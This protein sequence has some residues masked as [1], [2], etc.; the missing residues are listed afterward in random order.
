MQRRGALA[1]GQP[2]YTE[3]RS[4]FPKEVAEVARSRKSPVV[5]RVKDVAMGELKALPAMR[6]S[7]PGG[8]DTQE[9]NTRWLQS[10]SRSAADQ[11]L[12]DAKL[13]KGVFFFKPLKVAP[14]PPPGPP[15]APAPK[16]RRKEVYGRF[17][18]SKV[19][20]AP[21]PPSPVGKGM[22]QDCGGYK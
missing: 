3:I 15:P 5:R 10:R 18:S 16:V 20:P 6:P 17:P 4:M 7:F 11:A 21:R 13:G 1:P 14:A 19:A 12:A 22:C 2:A 8:I 9:S